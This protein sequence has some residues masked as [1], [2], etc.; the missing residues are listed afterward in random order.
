MIFKSES[1]HMFIYI[2]QPTIEHEIKH[3]NNLM[4]SNQGKILSNIH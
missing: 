2:I 3:E 4:S 1:I